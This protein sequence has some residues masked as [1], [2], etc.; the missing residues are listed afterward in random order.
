MVKK[1]TG[2]WV[3][4]GAAAI[5][6]AA[7]A[8]SNINLYRV[9]RRTKQ[10]QARVGELNGS[11]DSLSREIA[12]L[13]SDTTYIERMAREKLGMARTDEKVYKFVEEENR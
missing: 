2:R 9:Y 10:L 8:A 6:I 1:K 13:K 3:L 4:L 7:L 12:R 11:I 5:V